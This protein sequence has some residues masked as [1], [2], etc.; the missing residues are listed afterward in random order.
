VRTAATENQLSLVRLV[1]LA[2]DDREWGGNV[3]HE[4]KRADR[5]PVVAHRDGTRWLP[6][7]RPVRLSEPDV[8][9]TELHAGGRYLIT[10]GLGGIAFELA[11]YLL[12]AYQCRLLLVGRTAPDEL[13]ISEKASRLATLKELGDVAYLSVDVADAQKL[14]HAVESAEQRWGGPLNGVL[15]LA[16]ADMRAHWEQPENHLLATETAAELERI[17]RPKICGAMS[18]GALIADREHAHLVLF[19]SV[20]AE[21]GGVSFGAYSAANSFLSG[22][23]TS[24][25]GEHGRRV[26]SLAW[27]A[28]AGIGI[29]RGQQTAVKSSGF[30]PIGEDQGLTS[31]LAA[32]STD[33]DNLLIG[34][35]LSSPGIID[36]IAAEDLHTTEVTVA[37]TANAPVDAEALRSAIAQVASNPGVPVRARQVTALPRFADGEVDSVRLLEITARAAPAA[38][39]YVAPAT[40]LERKL[41]ESWMKVFRQ[42]RI[43]R[44]D[45]FF[46]LGGNSIQATQL[47]TLLAGTTDSAVSVQQLYTN[48]TI[49]QLAA[50]LTS[51]SNHPV[52]P[53]G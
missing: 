12:A 50:S 47:V 27:S 35:D 46:E 32:L 22:Y 43:G 4:L 8:P 28:W 1:D 21:F 6:K 41:S 15:H 30:L 3:G 48:P 14:R 10:G 37:Y 18:V 25:T 45:G 31:F 24:W 34:L 49:K 13:G 38:R 42:R 29:S 53:E 23:A 44:D 33:K 5:A 26:Q 20:N 11:Q 2:P 9:R 51:G 52:A 36:Q 19:S 7:L 17:C 39:P 16:G 40:D